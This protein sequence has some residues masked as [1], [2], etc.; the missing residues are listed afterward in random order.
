MSI[1]KPPIVSTRDLTYV[2]A[3]RLLVGEASSLPEFGR[4]WDDACDEGLTVVSHHTGREVVY[5]VALVSRDGEGDI[6]FWDLT[7]A[8]RAD[9]TLPTLRVFND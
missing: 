1:L 4:V 3:D 2:A 6:A 7:P 9:R 8:A 5:A